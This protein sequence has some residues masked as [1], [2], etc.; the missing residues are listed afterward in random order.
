MDS[1]FGSYPAGHLADPIVCRKCGKTGTV[2]WED[3]SRLSAS[4]PEL[5]GIDGPFFE[6]LS[7]KAPYPIELVCR[8]CG[9]VAI[10]AY[11]STSLHEREKYN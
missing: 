5:A 1:K 6:R 2:I 8:K 7:K 3:V 11:P 4:E 10:T 9:G